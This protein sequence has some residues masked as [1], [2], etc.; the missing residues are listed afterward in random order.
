[1]A[2]NVVAK[3]AAPTAASCWIAL[4]PFGQSAGG[5]GPLHCT[6]CRTADMLAAMALSIL[7]RQGF[8]VGVG[9]D[10]VS[11]TTAQVP[12]GSRKEGAGYS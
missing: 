4:L 11:N 3:L 2:P 10:V 6:A 8:T 7:T 1:M 9:E 12:P 5:L